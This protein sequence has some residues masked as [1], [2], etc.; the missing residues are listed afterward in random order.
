M[1]LGLNV[2]WFN[3]FK[4]YEDQYSQGIVFLSQ[5]TEYYGLSI[6]KPRTP[7][8]LLLLTLTAPLRTD[9]EDRF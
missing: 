4:Y 3:T 9:D 7:G 5:K 8:E 6:M 2:L 1:P